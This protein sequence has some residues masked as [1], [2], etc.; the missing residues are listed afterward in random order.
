[1]FVCGDDPAAKVTV[2][3]PAA[4]VGFD[5]IDAGPLTQARLRGPWAMLRIWLAF[6]GDAG[7]E[8]GF[9]RMKTG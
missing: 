6:R 2:L 5:P 3:G 4:D 8:F 7:R 1:M 9:A